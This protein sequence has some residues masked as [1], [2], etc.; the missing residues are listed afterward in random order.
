[1]DLSSLQRLLLRIAL[2]VGTVAG[3]CA[4]FGFHSGGV[5]ECEG[6][7]SIHNYQ[8][9][10]PTGV[11]N[12]F[13]LKAADP[14]STC[15]LCHQGMNDIGPTTYHVSTPT[16]EAPVGL[17]PKQLTPGG[18]F[19]W[20]KKEYLWTPAFGSPFQTSLG[21]SHGHNVVA[22]D[23]GYMEDARN[24]TAPGGDYASASLSCI[25]CHDP[26]GKYRRNTDG[27]I[28][29]S[30]LPIKSSGSFLS[31]PSPDPTA[32]VGVYRLLGGSG[33]LPKS[34]PAG[35]GFVYPSPAAVAPFP[36]NRSEATS[37]TRVVYGD[38]MS[39]WCRN[40]HASIHAGSSTF[41]HPVQAPLSSDMAQQYN[42]YVNFGDVSGTVAEAYSSLVPF[43]VGSSNYDLLRSIAINAPTK[44]P[45]PADGAAKLMCLSCHRAHAS[46]W[47]GIMRWNQKSQFVVYNGKYSQE[48]EV[49]QPYGQG[50]SEAEAQQAYYQ[51]PVSRFTTSESPSQPTL[52]QK[53]HQTLPQ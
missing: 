29:T 16:A 44:G 19:G 17:P 11:A 39:D 22:S 2:C 8:D 41:N 32:A 24:I 42:R 50:R 34:M 47:D 40:C 23:F 49:Y 51:I 15:L 30:G 27:S 28:T 20:L 3:P 6:C 9:G 4:A 48:G 46:G 25:S 21:D 12:P 52:C 14:S 37:M 36:A 53:C 5:G 13:L 43:E 33:Y 1:M 7:H 35:F 18:D 45:D 10:Q 26:H 38:G 31:S